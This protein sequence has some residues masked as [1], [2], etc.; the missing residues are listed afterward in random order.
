MKIKSKFKRYEIAYA[1]QFFYDLLGLESRKI[2]IKP[3]KKLNIPGLTQK[4]KESLESGEWVLEGWVQP[5]GI[6][7][8]EYEIYIEPTLRLKE[9]LRT[10]AHEMTHIKQYEQDGFDNDLGR[11]YVLF[12]GKKYPKDNDEKFYRSA[13]WEI[14][15]EENEDLLLEAFQDFIGE[16]L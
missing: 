11:D 9:Q 6:R 16:D 8:L 1:A 13:P 14:E 7:G 15:A 3:I 12:R 4:E 5:T 2:R 10:L